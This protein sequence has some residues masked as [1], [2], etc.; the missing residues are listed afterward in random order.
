[1]MTPELDK[2]CLLQACNGIWAS[3]HTPVCC[4]TSRAQAATH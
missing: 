4:S 2:H 1:M 3:L